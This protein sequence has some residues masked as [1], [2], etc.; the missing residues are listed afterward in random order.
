MYWNKSWLI[1]VRTKLQSPPAKG[2]FNPYSW[3]LTSFTVSV[4]IMLLSPWFHGVFTVFS[5]TYA[6]FW[7]GWILI[8]LYLFQTR[9]PKQLSASDI[10][11]IIYTHR[12]GKHTKCRQKNPQ[13]TSHPIINLAPPLMQPPLC[14]TNSAYLL[15][16]ALRNANHHLNNL[17][18]RR[19]LI[20]LQ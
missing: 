6:M 14:A 16:A 19:R 12:A 13:K 20:T 17:P 4:Q 7:K 15:F 1:S 5:G 8:R 2:E 18:G 3:A 10:N 11:H 9:A